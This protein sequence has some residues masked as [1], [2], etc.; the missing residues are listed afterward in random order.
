MLLLNLLRYHCNIA[1]GLRNPYCP[2]IVGLV[3]AYRRA[4]CYLTPHLLSSFRTEDRSDSV[5]S[6]KFGASSRTRTG[7]PQGHKILSLGRLPIPPYSHIKLENQ[8]LERTRKFFTLYVLNIVHTEGNVK[9]FFIFFTLWVAMHDN[10][11][12]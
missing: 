6:L 11:S 4:E 12:S 8:Q 9:H 10:I 3:S 7:T 2:P 5:T 1:T